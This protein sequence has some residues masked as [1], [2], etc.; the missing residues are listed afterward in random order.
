AQRTIGGG[1]FLD[2]RAPARKRRTPQ[3][4]AQLEACL[5]DD[6]ERALAALSECAPGYVDLATFARYRALRADEV[7]RFAERLDLVTMTLHRSVLAMSPDRWDELRRGILA[8]LAAFHADNPDQPGLGMERLRLQIEPRLPAAAFASALQVLARAKQIAFDG[9]WIRLPDHEMRLTSSEQS[10]WHDVEPML[11]AKERFRPPRVRD[12]VGM[13][14]RREDEV[15]GLLKLLG[16]LGEVDEVTHDHLFLRSAVNE[17]VDIAVDLAAKAPDGQFA[18]AQFRD[19]LD[20]GRKVAIQILEFFDRHGVTLRRGDLRRIN[21][22]RLDLFGRLA[23]ER[24]SS[25]DS[26]RESSPVGRPDF[27]SGR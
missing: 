17:M 8:R 5:N 3:R 26:G 10:L 1:R 13:T 4:I 2:L 25:T 22:A 11:A 6:G 16:R 19:R 9:A 14:D 21:K 12:I 15:R 7:A 24:S 27:K 20:N 18:A 23:D